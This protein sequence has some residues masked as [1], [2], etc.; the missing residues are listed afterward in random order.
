MHILAKDLI[1][2]DLCNDAFC[3]Y[4]EFRTVVDDGDVSGMVAYSG[5]H[6]IRFNENCPL[7][8]RYY[9]DEDTLL[10]DLGYEGIT[11]LFRLYNKEAEWFRMI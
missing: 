9:P 3:D 4:A 8:K 10:V 6:H 2:N 5:S 7:D 11:E 1:E